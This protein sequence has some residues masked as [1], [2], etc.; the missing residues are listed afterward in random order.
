MSKP[1][2]YVQHDVFHGREGVF[3]KYV[4]GSFQAFYIASS[5]SRDF[6]FLQAI[7]A[8]LIIPDKSSR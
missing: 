1:L 6:D 3:I 4:C 8:L 2:F 7:A 5:V